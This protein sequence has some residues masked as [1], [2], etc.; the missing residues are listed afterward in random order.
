MQRAKKNKLSATAWTRLAKAFWEQRQRRAAPGALTGY[1][2][3][4]SPPAIGRQRFKGEWRQAQTWLDTEKAPAGRCLDLGCGTGLW[5]QA[6]AGRFKSVEA[7]DYAPA[8]I[9]ASR[10]HLAMAGIR[11][12]TLRCGRIER[13]PGRA[14]FDFI[15]VGGVLMYTPQAKLIPLLKSLTRLLKPNGR[16]LL[17]ESTLAGPTWLRKNSPLRPGLLA[18]A[19]QRQALDY[20]AIYRSPQA[21]TLAL[22]N[23][24]FTLKS[25]HPNAHYKLSDLSEDWLR[26]FD[27]VLG[28]RLRQSA[29]RAELA[30]TWI[31]RARL[32]L[33]Y[34]EYF[35]R[36]TLGLGAFKLV[37]YW[38]LCART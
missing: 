19:R 38:F 17:R 7:W 5:A 31:Y 6:L 9:K 30:A 24:G 12:V 36:Q 27:W 33:L 3:D 11:N 4:E 15:F 10:R 23:A 13:R 16:L 22:A 8:M 37:N 25:R 21:L 35:I 28:G 1:L 2:L 20:V 34:P 18:N 26:R 29:I 14:V 32:L